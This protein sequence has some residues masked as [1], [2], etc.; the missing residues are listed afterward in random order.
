VED[1][2]TNQ[3]LAQMTLSRAGITVDVA[4]DGIESLEMCSRTTYS[5]ILMDI[6]M[7]RMGGI[8]ATQRLRASGLKTPIIALTA[9]ALQSEKQKCLEVGFVD[10]ITKPHTPQEL[11]EVVLRYRKP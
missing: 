2:V 1:N 5:V 7:P 6:N 10:F 8:E 3:R 9:N 4:E 11:V